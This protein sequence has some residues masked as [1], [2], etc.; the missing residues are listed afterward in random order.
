MLQRC[1]TTSIMVQL[2]TKEPTLCMT[3][4]CEEIARDVR[5]VSQPVC[6]L[7]RQAWAPSPRHILRGTAWYS[8]SDIAIPIC[9]WI[10]LVPESRK[11]K[12]DVARHFRHVACVR[13]R[14]GQHI[15]YKVGITG[16][17]ESSA[18][19]WISLTPMCR[20]LSSPFTR[21]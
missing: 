5:C 11:Q 17:V 4:E 13:H 10:V 16:W 9:I 1:W 3:K 8:L 2:H 18:S 21:L 15:V 19:E 6:R 20:A 12:A 14:K 7:R